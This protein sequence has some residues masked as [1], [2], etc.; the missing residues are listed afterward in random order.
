MAAPE[1]CRERANAEDRQLSGG[2]RDLSFSPGCRLLY[3]WAVSQ[4]RTGPSF[5]DVAGDI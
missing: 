2:R 5:V 1:V 4:E 3:I